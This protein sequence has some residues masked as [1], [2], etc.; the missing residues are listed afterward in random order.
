MGGKYI[1]FVSN[2]S[3][4]ILPSKTGEIMTRFK[5]HKVTKD[6]LKKVAD[7]Y[8]LE[9]IRN[10]LEK[11]DSLLFKK[12]IYICLHNIVKAASSGGDVLEALRSAKNV[13]NLPIF[14]VNAQK[15]IYLIKNKP[16]FE[17]AVEELGKFRN[18][19]NLNPYAIINTFLAII[20][21]QI[22][23]FDLNDLL[24][25][26]IAHV[27]EFIKHSL[28]T[29]PNWD[30]KTLTMKNPVLIIPI[31]AA[32]TGKSTYYRELPNV[33][34][35]SCDNIRYL[36]FR[37]FGPCFSPWESTLAWWVVNQLT[38]VYISKGYSVFYNGVNT[39][40][41]YRSP[42]TME[43][44]DPLYAG[45]PYKIKLVYFEPPVKLTAD[46]LKELKS[47]DLW[48]NPIDGLDL[49]KFSPNVA[50]ILELIKTN[51]H[52]TLARTK[53]IKEGKRAQD[54]YDVLYSVPAAI[55]K[56]F[57]EQSFDVPK[58]K[59]VIIIPRKEIPDETERSKFY[60]GYAAKVM[61]A[62]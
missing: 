45:I 41:E 44:P 2:L 53:E 31:G 6:L 48:A 36:L 28:K 40:L 9:K 12:D 33:I 22:T 17:K 39:D 11:D 55:V 4:I 35:I 24:Q 47:V 49:S 14:A 13:Y 16:D 46:E 23:G 60:R 10:I 3:P 5:C 59:N 52:R 34:N 8:E 61:E 62:Q 51:Y 43:N 58:G 57:V 19:F 38:D 25:K 54:P 27:E 56:L 15:G 30:E 32:G 7:K 18:C 50:K 42:L 26:G 37:E 1:S 29:S 20:E 21:A